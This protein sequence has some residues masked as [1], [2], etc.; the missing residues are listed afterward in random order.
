MFEAWIEKSAG[1]IPIPH[2]YLLS[3]KECI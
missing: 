1:N 2:N 3:T